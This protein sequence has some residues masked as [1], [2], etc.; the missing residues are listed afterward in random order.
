MIAD[1]VP[2]LEQASLRLSELLDPT[3]NHTIIVDS[4]VPLGK[5]ACQ[6]TGTYLK[7]GAF[8]FV[9][10]TAQHTPPNEKTTQGVATFDE[11]RDT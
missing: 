1:P 11:T 6:I 9:S 3:E 4:V 7:D 10:I 5:K 2:P 8:S